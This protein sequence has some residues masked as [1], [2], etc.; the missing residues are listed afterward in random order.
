MVQNYLQS[1]LK[2]GQQNMLNGDWVL[3]TYMFV[4][5]NGLLLRG[6][7]YIAKITASLVQN[8]LQSSLK[9]GQKNM[10]NGDWV[11]FTYMFVAAVATLEPCVFVQLLKLC[12]GYMDKK[13]ERRVCR[14]THME[15]NVFKER[16]HDRQHV[17]RKSGRINGSAFCSNIFTSQ[18]MSRTFTA[19][20][21]E[22]L[23]AQPCSQH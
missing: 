13:A 3:F 15:N 10:L 19:S 18:N 21:S 2:D 23:P 4:S 12:L 6:S 16:P 11:P 20:R 1:S 22:H 5:M 7:V 17:F 14:C 8:Y 9:Y